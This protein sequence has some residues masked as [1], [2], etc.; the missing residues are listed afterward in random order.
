MATP[1]IAQIT[2]FAGNFAP[3]SWALCAGQILSIAQNTALFSLVGTIYGGNG[4][5]TFGLPDLRGRMPIGWGQGPGLSNYSQG[6][7]AGTETVTLVTSNLPAHS[8]T[9]TAAVKAGDQAATDSVP[10]GNYL[11]DGNQYTGTQ[12]TTMKSDMVAVTV[13]PTGSNA[14]VNNM[15]PFL[16]ITYIIALQGIYPSR[17]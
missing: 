4:T 11:A 3:R 2:I 13:N 15:P 9:A 5:T 17:N 16:A 8:H 12:N 6:E 14:P 7:M 1:F 10:T